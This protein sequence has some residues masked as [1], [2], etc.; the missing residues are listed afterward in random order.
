MRTEREFKGYALKSEGAWFG[1]FD[2]WQSDKARRICGDRAWAEAVRKRFPGSVIV[3]VWI[4][5]RGSKQVTLTFSEVAALQDRAED[6]ELRAETAEARVKELEEV[7][8]KLGNACA[9]TGSNPILIVAADV[10]AIVQ[11]ALEKK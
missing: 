7:V 11:T 6:A 9:Y 5:P 4:V 2:L 10:R 1:A 8:R 3:H